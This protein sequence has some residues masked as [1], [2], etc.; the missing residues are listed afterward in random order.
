M[1]IRTKSGETLKVNI[2]L[3]VLGFSRLKYICL[4]S[5]RTQETL[6]RYL[7]NAFDFFG[8]VPQEILFDN[9]KTVVNHSKSTFTKVELNQTFKYFASDAGFKP[10]TCRPY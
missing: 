10:I 9:M 1:S 2:F 6:F 8:G 3:I 5:D 4:T 7:M